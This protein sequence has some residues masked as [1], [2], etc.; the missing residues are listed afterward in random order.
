MLCSHRRLPLPARSATLEGRPM[1]S[2]TKLSKV[3]TY[4]T[5]VASGAIERPTYGSTSTAP[6]TL[7]M[8]LI[9]G[10]SL[11]F[12]LLPALLINLPSIF[13]IFPSLMLLPCLAKLYRIAFADGW[14]LK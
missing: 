4:L 5:A 2:K 9:R 3:S 14:T 1:P 11:L 13:A 6:M 12:L 8:N 7:Q 10:L